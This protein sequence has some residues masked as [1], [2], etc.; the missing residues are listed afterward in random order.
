MG[1]SS[2]SRFLWV[3]DPIDGTK[4]FITGDSKASGCHDTIPNFLWVLDLIDGTKS[5]ITGERGGHN[6]F[7]VTV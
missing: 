4:S 2:G 5:F 1:G 7:C 3:L 6:T